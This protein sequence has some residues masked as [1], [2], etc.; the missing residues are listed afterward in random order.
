MKHGS[1]GVETTMG[2]S[3]MGTSTTGTDVSNNKTE[4]KTM[5]GSDRN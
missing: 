3:T 4:S 1:D 2:T 5:A